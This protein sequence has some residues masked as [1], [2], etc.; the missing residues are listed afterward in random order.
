M[1]D[2][3][4]HQPVPAVHCQMGHM[5]HCRADSQENRTNNTIPTVVSLPRHLQRNS[6]GVRHLSRTSPGRARRE[7]RIPAQDRYNACSYLT[8]TIWACKTHSNQSLTV[9]LLFPPLM[10]LKVSE[11]PTECYTVCRDWLHPPNTSLMYASTVPI[12]SVSLKYIYGLDTTINFSIS[13]SIDCSIEG[14]INGTPTS[15]PN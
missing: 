14:T 13:L 6:R 10:G 2:P 4:A 5:A 12:V 3:V 11:I 7:D 15:A 9:S 1:S 8:S